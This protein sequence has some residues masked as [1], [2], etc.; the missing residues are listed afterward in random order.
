MSDKKEFRVDNKKVL[1]IGAGLSGRAAAQFLAGKGAKVTLTD[2][3]TAEELEGLA[4]IAGVELLLGRM[5]EA[6]EAAE[7]DLAVISPGVPLS[8]PLAADLQAA[9]VPLIGELELAWQ[10]SHNPYLAITGTNGK[11]TTTTLLG[12]ILEQAGQQPLVG[13]NIG[14]PL[15]NAVE[16]LR[17]GENIVAELS[18]FQLETAGDF[19]AHIAAF[20]NLTPDHLYRHGTMEN[21]GAIKAKIFAH[22]TEADYAVLN[23]DD[24]LVRAWGDKLAGTVVFFGRQPGDE[25]QIK[26]GMVLIDGE[27]RWRWQGK[28]QRLLRAE[29][30][31]IKGPHNLENAMAA[32]AMALLAGIDREVVAAALRSF[33]GV[34]HRQEPV[35]EFGGV[36][37]VNDSKGTNP[38]STIMALAACTRPTV[39]ILGGFEKNSDFSPLLPLI[40]EKVKHIVLVG[41][42][43]ERI[44]ETLRA[45][46]FSDFENAG[47]DF[48]KCVRL[49]AA[50]AEPGDEVL[51]SPA[52][53]SWGMFNNFE[54]R[55]EM[56]KQLVREIGADLT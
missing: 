52:S 37:Y 49:A 23:Y 10:F 28:E 12:Y 24:E 16:G 45:G 29:E 48:A 17:P 20:L 35:G 53:A 7:F 5:P 38:D 44:G 32:A 56:F 15:V 4:A 50:A 36:L 6:K 43:A 9:K 42:T 14:T 25:A 54:E 2:S 40:R 8:I 3:K 51:L 46:G 27:V 47:L 22:Q 34:E 18:S 19:H 13:G 55:G 31:L 33:P 39:L 41:Q 1:V 26:Q 21:Y 30:I 11:T